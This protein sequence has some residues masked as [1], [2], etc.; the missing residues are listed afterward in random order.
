MSATTMGEAMKDEIKQGFDSA[1]AKL[2]ARDDAARRADEQRISERA[3]FETAYR[4]AVENVI[5]PALEEVRRLLEAQKWI[6][7]VSRV[8]HNL[9]VTLEAQGDKHA[10]DAKQ[11]P[12]ISFSR[13]PHEPQMNVHTETGQQGDGG[14][15]YPLEAITADLI[16]EHALKFVQRLADGH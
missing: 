13:D 8:E 1:F 14:G 2:R 7:R 12:H 16:Q 6:S 4:T 11:R 3:K 9:E 15:K 5:V 10:I